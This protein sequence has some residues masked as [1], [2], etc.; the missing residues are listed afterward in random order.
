MASPQVEDG[1]TRIAN[2]ILEHLMRLYLPANRWQVLLCV[3][4]KTYGFNKKVDWIANFQIAEATGLVKSTVSR[5]LK[6]LE[7]QGL[8]NRKGKYIGFQK[9]WE[10]WKVSNAAN[11]EPKVSS[12]A[13][14]EKLAVQLTKVSNPATQLAIL[15]TKVSNPFV[16][17]KTKDTI[18]KD[19]IQK[20]REIL[21]EWINKEIWKDFL[22]MRKKIK[23]SPTDRAK[24]LLIKTLDTLRSQGNDP[25]R[26]L[27]QSIM[28]NYKGL[29]PLKGGQDGKANPRG[30]VKHYTR[31]DEL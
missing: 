20:T 28:N 8:V 2:E 6:Q 15:S 12:S 21:P 4:R 17:Q 19:T 24:E 18:T 29:F 22:E 13:N 9:D 11:S 7:E 16:T 25:N 1:H 10:K 26:V 30:L 23:S 5:S 3:I 31:P 27:E 14:N